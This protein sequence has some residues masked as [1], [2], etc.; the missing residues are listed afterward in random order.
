MSKPF[1]LAVAGLML[2]L[3]A[4]IAHS[5]PLAQSSAPIQVAQNSSVSAAEASYNLG[6]AKY[7]ANDLPAALA[8]FNEAIRLNP[9]SAAAFMNRANVKDDMG[10]PQGAIEDYNQAI[11]LDDTSHTIYFNRGLTYS[12]IQKYPEAI[13]DFNKSLALEPTF[14]PAYR[15]RGFCKYLSAKSKQMRLEGMADV[16]KAIE[17]YRAQ[18]DEKSATK[19][20]ATLNDM[21]AAVDS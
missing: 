19:T 13:A 17:L 14:A 21:Q 15:G 8:A 6:V 5:A 20:E 18:G 3:S 1:S 2:A 16:R 4:P 9:R 10:D 12:R 7:Q 11:K